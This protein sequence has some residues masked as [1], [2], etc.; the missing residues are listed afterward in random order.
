MALYDQTEQQSL[1]NELRGAI[2]DIRRGN[3]H[4]FAYFVCQLYLLR[5][6]PERIKRVKASCGV[7]ET[8]YTAWETTYYSLPQDQRDETENLINYFAGGLNE[9]L[10]FRI[11]QDEYGVD[12]LRVQEIRSYEKPTV[13]GR[14]PTTRLPYLIGAAIVRGSLIP[15]IDLRIKLG[16]REPRYDTLTVVIVIQSRDKKYRSG[17]VVDSVSDVLV[18]P[19]QDIRGCSAHDRA[20]GVARGVAQVGDRFIRLVNLDTEA[21]LASANLELVAAQT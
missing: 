6:E 11:G 18:I 2:N 15:F 1:E 21:F 19:R 12:V 8:E 16:V 20:V 5:V 17:I 13:P 9:Y 3:P 10:T 7:T 4:A 14:R